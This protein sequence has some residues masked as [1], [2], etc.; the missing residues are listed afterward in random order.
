MF[1]EIIMESRKDSVVHQRTT[2]VW[3]NGAMTGLCDDDVVMITIRLFDS[4]MAMATYDGDDA[5]SLMRWYD[6]DEAIVFHAIVT[7][8]SHHF[9]Y[10]IAPSR[11]RFVYTSAV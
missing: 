9:F 11:Y 2:Q 10:I 5:T 6:C 7:A 3:V 8:L 4:V 1:Q